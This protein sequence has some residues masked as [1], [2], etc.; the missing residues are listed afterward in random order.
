LQS[1]KINKSINPAYEI[2]IKE[3]L[4]I[5]E[6]I[7]DESLNNQITVTC[8]PNARIVGKKL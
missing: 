6:L 8:V 5:K 4:N 2:I 1:L 7:I 3:E